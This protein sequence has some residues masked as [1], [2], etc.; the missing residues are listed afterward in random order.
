MARPSLGA[1]KKVT[2]EN[3]AGLGAARLAQIL[4]DVAETRVD[5]KRRLR[6]ELAA[7]QGAGPLTAEIDKRLNAFETSR[8]QVGWRQGPAFIRDLDALRDLVAA[9]LAPLD[10]PAA[11]DRLWRLMDSAKPLARR[12]RDRHGELEAVFNRTARDLGNL[13]AT[14]QGGSGPEKL[15]KSLAINPAGWP[16]WLPS[17]LEAVP[18]DFAAEALR[19]MEGT[20]TA[21]GRA[22]II[23][24]L[25]SAAGD[26]DTYASTYS[27]DAL[28]SPNV[29]A[30][31]ARRYLAAGRPD[32][33]EQAL[34]AA[35]PKA[36]VW[37]RGRAVDYDWESA[38]IDLLEQTGRTDEA[39]TLRWS[40]FER[41]LSAE[42][43]RAFV[44]RLSGF[45]DVEAETR[46]FEIA[47]GAA[48][49]P[50]GL[51]FLLDWPALAEAARMIEARRGDIALDGAE[52]ELWAA[53]LR[54][55]FP[56][57]AL[58]LLRGAAAAAFRRR[59]FKTCDR[60]SEEA[61]SLEV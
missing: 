11:V 32:E 16:S 43:A 40:S 58:A 9:R 53:K 27:R 36:A 6:M 23:R 17:L 30:D 31:L 61:E 45:D 5:L 14:A 7:Q 59:D 12:Y 37:G 48:D 19:S 46:A 39:Q 49:L 1:G 51:R 50:A 26:I 18:R 4:A 55:R 8:G 54:R 20:P 3:L 41:T 13:L 57:A 33:A 21:P 22:T 42:R 24:Q 15:I 10:A 60:L 25:A 52:A 56:K 47:A 29:A 28:R 44:K 34:M 35:A 38:Q 2:P